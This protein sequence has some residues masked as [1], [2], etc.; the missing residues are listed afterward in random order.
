M[1]SWNEYY[2]Y[3]GYTY[4][5]EEDFDGDVVKN[6]HIVLDASKKEIDRKQV[7]DWG[8]YNVPTFSQFQQFV[9]DH[10]VTQQPDITSEIDEFYMA[11]ERDRGNV[12]S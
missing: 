8:P 1:H 11:I 3:L 2:T 12:R 10:I 5:L 4:V 7:P 6:V 9:I